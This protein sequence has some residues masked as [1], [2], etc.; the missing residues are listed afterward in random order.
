MNVTC[1]LPTLILPD[2]FRVAIYQVCTVREKK[3]PSN[4]WIFFLSTNVHFGFE[5]PSKCFFHGFE[6]KKGV[7]LFI[8]LFFESNISCYICHMLMF[9]KHIQCCVLLT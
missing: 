9:L 8:Y 3:Q 7:H 2:N 5:K 1:I 4:V 6:K